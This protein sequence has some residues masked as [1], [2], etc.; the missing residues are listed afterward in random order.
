MS[1]KC[2]SEHRNAIGNI[3]V[4]GYKNLMIQSCC[5]QM[6]TKKEGKIGNVVYESRSDNGCCGQYVDM[7]W[8]CKDT[9]LFYIKRGL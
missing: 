3:V 9:K 4:D 6:L 8:F 1:K 2:V 7:E 5:C